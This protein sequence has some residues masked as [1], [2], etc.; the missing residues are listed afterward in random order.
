[1]W[2]LI[3][4]MF[5]GSQVCHPGQF[6]GTE[7]KDNL[8]VLGILLWAVPSVLIAGFTVMSR[9]LN[10]DARWFD[11]GIFK[12]LWRGSPAMKLKQIP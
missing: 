1:M 9:T 10:I 3:G 6:T 4:K 5:P 11:R 12:L 8:I 2:A 7:D